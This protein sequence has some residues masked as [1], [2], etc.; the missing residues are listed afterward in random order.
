MKMTSGP[1][2]SEADKV[3]VV[4]QSGNVGPGVTGHPMEDVL[5]ELV[6]VTEQ[7]MM[8]AFLLAVTATEGRLRIIQQQH[9]HRGVPAHI[10]FNLLAAEL[11]VVMKEYFPSPS[12]PEKEAPDVVQPQS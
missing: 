11:R 6:R 3:A 8:T 5:A 1:K 12:S 7:K 4:D 10:P 9:G 2:P